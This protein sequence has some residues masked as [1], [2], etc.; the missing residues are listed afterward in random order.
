VV[1][2]VA[3]PRSPVRSSSPGLAPTVSRAWRGLCL[4]LR[5]TLPRRC[6]WGP[7]G[8]VHAGSDEFVRHHRS[9]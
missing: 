4:P 1:A 7:R 5:S 9:L 3:S 6:G 8:R 2:A